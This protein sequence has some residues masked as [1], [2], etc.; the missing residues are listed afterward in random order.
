MHSPRIGDSGKT[1][2]SKKRVMAREHGVV[3]CVVQAQAHIHYTRL[4]LGGGAE[5]LVMIA[6]VRSHGKRK[7]HDR[8]LLGGW[9]YQHGEGRVFFQRA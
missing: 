1:E 9:S 3:V 4:R 8:V 5:R 6:L 2:R 7:R